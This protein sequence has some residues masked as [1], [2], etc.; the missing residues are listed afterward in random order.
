MGQDCR[1]ALRRTEL[2]PAMN[3]LEKIADAID[4]FSTFIG[5]ILS[6]V[7]IPVVAVSFSVVVM[8]YAFGKGYPW[9]QE[10]YIWMHGAAVLLC[11]AWVLKEGGHVRVDLFYKKW[12]ATT[13][14][15]SDLFGVVVFLYPMMGF[16]FWWSLPVVQR[17]WRLLERSPTSD[18]LQ[19]VYL[20]KTV[21][22][23]FCVLVMIQ[24][25]SMAFRSI[26]LIA[27]G[28]KAGG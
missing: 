11:A 10:A 4:A 8:R 17:S 2:P 9:M 27:R 14:A 7:M 26:V 1:H 13:R 23:V 28:E 24:G 16:L 21:I 5:R 22:P 18:G 12:T 19:F 3:A 15:W 6:W 25:L 20:M